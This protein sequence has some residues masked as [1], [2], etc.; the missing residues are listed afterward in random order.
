[1]LQMLKMMSLVGAMAVAWCGSAALAQ[2]PEKEPWMVGVNWAGAEF[3]YGK[4]PGEEGTHFHWPNAESLDYYAGKG[5][6]LIRLPFAWERLQPELNG[7]LDEKYLAGMVRSVKLIGD[8]K[9]KVALDMHNYARY[10][11]EL[12]GSEKVPND[13][14][15]DVWQK[16]ATVFNGN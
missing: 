4:F 12:I 9:M 10:R 11:L 2:A 6:T 1:M 13:A 3:A 7:P 8:R 5:I 14:F 16:L 15:R